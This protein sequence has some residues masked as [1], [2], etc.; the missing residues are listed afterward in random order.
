MKKTIFN[1]KRERRQ[2]P[3]EH[4]R[5]RDTTALLFHAFT[6]LCYGKRN[7]FD[8]NNNGV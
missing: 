7:P 8:V 1:Y 2:N 6:L 3:F 4:R 5:D